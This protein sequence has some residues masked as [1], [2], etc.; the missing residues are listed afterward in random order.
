MVVVEG[1][2]S[3]STPRF[4]GTKAAEDLLRS[5]DSQFGSIVFSMPEV[6]CFLSKEQSCLL[7]NHPS[8]GDNFDHTSHAHH[9]PGSF[10]QVFQRHWLRLFETADIQFRRLETSAAAIHLQPVDTKEKFFPFLQMFRW[11]SA[12][13]VDAS[14]IS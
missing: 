3:A 7:L 10:L 13:T 1:P 12:R 6:Y 8:F 5:L 2:D 4:P 11:G 9:F 14:F